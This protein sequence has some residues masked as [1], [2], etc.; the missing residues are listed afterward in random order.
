MK[1]V[2]RLTENDLMRIVKRVI[3]ENKIGQQFLRR[4]FSNN[5][6]DIIKNLSDDAVKELDGLL[7]KVFNPKNMSGGMI[8]SQSGAKISKNTIEDIIRLSSTGKLDIDTVINRLPRNL[9]DG[10]KFRETIKDIVSKKRPTNVV[11]LHNFKSGTS[12][13]SEYFKQN[14]NLIDFTNIRNAKTIDEYNKLIATAIRNND[15]RQISSRGFEKFGIPNF[16]EF[17]KN[18]KSLERGHYIDPSRGFWQ[19]SVK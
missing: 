5:A 13:S 19:F 10:T 14:S 3:S 18:S 9:A 11:K 7:S 6:D 4:F 17:L 1:K 8:L 15:Y 16:R 2:V 12:V